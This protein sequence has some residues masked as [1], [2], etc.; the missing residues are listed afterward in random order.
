MQ[1]ISIEPLPTSKKRKRI[2]LDTRESFV[3]YTG[4]IRKHSEL[5]EGAFLSE[6]DYQEILTK[7]LL[8]R[9]KKRTLHLLEKQDRTRA[10]VI[11]KLTQGGYPSGIA[12]AA[13]DYAASYGYIDDRRY[14]SNFIYFHQEKK[15]RRR[16]KQ[17]LLRKGISA[18]IID[19]C[20]E[21]AELTSE[22]DKIHKLLEK[23]HYVPETATDKD[24]ARMVRF[25]LGRGFD[26]DKIRTAI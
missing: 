25:L 9:A 11:M 12:E 10:D 13:A 20:L 16:L 2:T 3:L 6:A 19:K 17:D 14:A 7:I 26:Y 1:I 24:R 4:E 15:S 21:E 23:K 22:E 5:K 18:D 8:P